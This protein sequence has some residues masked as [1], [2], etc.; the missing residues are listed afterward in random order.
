MVD[1]RER[2]LFA[3]TGASPVRAFV[4]VSV[5]AFREALARG[6]G[7][8]GIEVV[9]T[10]PD[11]ASALPCIA[12]LEPDVVLL[13]ALGSERRLAVAGLRA[14]AT[15]L[16]VVALGV[17]DEPAEAVA[18]VEAGASGYVTSEQSVEEAADVLR[19]VA[20]GE[21]P[22]TGQVAAILAGRVSELS[23]TGSAPESP[24][25]RL[26]A[27]EREIAG[28]IGAGLSNKEIA[29]LLGIELTTVKNHVHSIL[30]KLGVT[31]RSEVAARVPPSPSLWAADPAGLPGPQKI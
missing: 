12:E 29:R 19:S 8:A 30:A 26:T 16:R 15:G 5:R 22:C 4:I 24:P 3:V 23:R 2:A 7:G 18:L 10:A 17:A 25:A 1:L 6:L 11:S 28:L 13:E 20:D 21:F 31:R 14:A 9:G 27:R